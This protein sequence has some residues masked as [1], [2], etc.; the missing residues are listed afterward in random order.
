[1]T[2]EP[3]KLGEETEREEALDEKPKNILM[4]LQLKT[5]MDPDGKNL[6][7]ST[8]RQGRLVYR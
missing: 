1:M 7:M 8:V 5:G 4:S 3:P 2:E 6:T